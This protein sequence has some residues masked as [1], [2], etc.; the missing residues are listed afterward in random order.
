M[1]HMLKDIVTIFV[2]HGNLFGVMTIMVLIIGYFK[3]LKPFLEDFDGVKTHL[4]T[5]TDDH[6]ELD[7]KL[8]KLKDVIDNKHLLLIKQF[9]ESDKINSTTHETI[10]VEL[11][12]ELHKIGYRLDETTKRVV[13]S[14]N[15]NTTAH[16][17]VAIDLTRIQSRLD[18]MSPSG[19][20][21]LQK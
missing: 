1:E 20:R 4:H 14:D 21:G 12:T 2:D 11:L 9:E 19:A 10:K 7:H 6:K 13:E 3:Y 16:R 18:Y 8:A 17:E 5:V 15:R